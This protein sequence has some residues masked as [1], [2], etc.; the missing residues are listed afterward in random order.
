MDDDLYGDEFDIEAEL[1]EINTE[2]TV[3]AETQT[4]T[5]DPAVTQVAT[6]PP[7]TEAKIDIS[8]NKIL[9]VVIVGGLILLMFFK[10]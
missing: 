10:K 7:T 9:P 6:V 1:N 2:E 5:T 8:K 3:T 4:V